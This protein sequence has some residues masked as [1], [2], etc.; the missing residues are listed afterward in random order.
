VG[1][2]PISPAPDLWDN[3]LLKTIHSLALAA[4]L[5][6]LPALL[7]A[8]E[9]VRLETEFNYYQHL[10]VLYCGQLR[11]DPTPQN[12]A[13]R[14]WA[15]ARLA[16]VTSELTDLTFGIPL[17]LPAGPGPA[18][19]AVSTTGV[20]QVPDAPATAA[21]LGIALLALGLPYLSRKPG[22]PGRG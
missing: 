4:T 7:P 14:D 10:Y 9:Q 11:A 1:V 19:V 8:N 17:P 16:F 5:G 3:A 18:Q 22:C 21:L 12:V 6:L 20:P 13:N 15:E 2:Q